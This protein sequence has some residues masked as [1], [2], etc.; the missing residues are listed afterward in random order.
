MGVRIEN[1]GSGYSEAKITFGVPELDIQPAEAKATITDGR[2]TSIQVTFGSF[3]YFTIPKVNITGNGL[4]FRENIV[5]ALPHSCTLDQI[6]DYPT[7]CVFPN[8]VADNLSNHPRDFSQADINIRLFTN[9][10]FKQLDDLQDDVVL[11]VNHFKE[12]STVPVEDCYV[13]AVTDT[14]D[15]LWESDIIISDIAVSVLFDRT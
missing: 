9:Y 15:V 13:T 4:S 11:L 10:N 7:A 12:L 14:S 3:G 8:T 6:C 5:D 1:P 2:V